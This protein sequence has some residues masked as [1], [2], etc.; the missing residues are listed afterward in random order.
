VKIVKDKRTADEQ[1]KRVNAETEKISRE[2]A[3]ANDIAQVVQA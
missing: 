1:E 2:A 3:E